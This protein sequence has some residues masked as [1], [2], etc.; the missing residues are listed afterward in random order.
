MVFYND[1]IRNLFIG[2]VF[3]I[4]WFACGSR[5]ADAH[6]SR[7]PKSTRISFDTKFERN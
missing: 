7:S 5:E 6:F 1:L 3:R 2:L 4:V